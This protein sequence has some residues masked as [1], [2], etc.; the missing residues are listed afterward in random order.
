MLSHALS[1]WPRPPPPP[2][3]RSRSPPSLPLQI[4]IVSFVQQH[5]RRPNLVCFF[6]DDREN[7]MCIAHM[8]R[9]PCGN[10]DITLVHPPC[11]L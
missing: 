6:E 9:F 7:H 2:P 5:K 10:F 8:F 1:V 11:V 3:P 4:N